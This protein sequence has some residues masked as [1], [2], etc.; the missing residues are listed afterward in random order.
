M[1][2]FTHLT[3]SDLKVSLYVRM[4][5]SVQPEILDGLP[6]C[7]LHAIASRRDLLRI[8]HLMGNYRWLLRTV[9]RAGVSANH[10]L[11]EIGAG[12]GTLTKR[13]ARALPASSVH[14]LDLCGPPTD[15]PDPDTWISGDLLKFQKF[16]NYTHLIAN[17][18]LHHFEDESLHALG[19]TLD[20][21][22]I[23][24]IIACEPCRRP[25][26]TYQLRAGKWIGFNHVTLHDGVVSVRAGFRGDEL[27]NLLGLARDRWSWS[28]RETWMGAYRLEASRR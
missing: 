27:P 5:R 21:S 8:N 11:L 24:K 28:V 16:A 19:Q 13:L 23:R 15:W 20:Q 12:D 4:R 18:I 2:S 1:E 26:H 25:L 9:R 14:A 3:H 7:N 22:G 17:L 10:R 6:A